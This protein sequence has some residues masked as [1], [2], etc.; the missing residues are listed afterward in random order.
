MIHFNTFLLAFALVLGFSTE[1]LAEK[2][3]GCSNKKLVLHSCSGVQKAPRKAFC[4][5]KGIN[6]TQVE[7]FCLRPVK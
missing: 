2:K 6:K 5:K 7:K 4:G 1:L 3:L